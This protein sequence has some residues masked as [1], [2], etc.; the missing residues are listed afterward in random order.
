MAKLGCVTAQQSWHRRKS[1]LAFRR[2]SQRSSSH[3]L[4]VVKS[5]VDFPNGSRLTFA[6]SLQKSNELLQTRMTTLLAI[7]PPLVL[8]LGATP[9]EL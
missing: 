7:E 2:K 9:T 1:A 5:A 8:E 3:D 4:T 6:P